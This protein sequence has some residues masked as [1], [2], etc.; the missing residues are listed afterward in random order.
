MHKYKK[1]GFLLL[2]FGVIFYGCDAGNTDVIQEGEYYLYYTNKEGTELT[3][4]T[5][6]PESQETLEVAKEML[7]R[8]SSNTSDITKVKTIPTGVAVEEINIADN[9]AS[10]T[11]S[12]EFLELD[13][14]DNIIS[15]SSVVLTLT[16][17]SDIQYVRMYAGGEELKDQS[18]NSIGAMQAGD[19]INATADIV[20]LYTKTDITLYFTNE[21][22]DMLKPYTYESVISNKMSV[23]KYIV[24]QL[25]NGPTEAG[26]GR[27]ISD[28]V[29]LIGV[30]TKDDICYVNLGTNFLEESM[31]IKSE[32][33]I[34]SIVN[35]LS[36]LSYINKVQIMVNGET[37][38]SY[39][40]SI[41]LSEAL[42]R[43]LD[44]IE[45]FSDETTISIIEE[46]IID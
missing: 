5:F 3:T 32:I 26:Y 44:Y 45:E 17:L 27:V 41:S 30:T 39:H 37:D 8:L 33:T 23:E 1:L 22:G 28:K 4:M 13:A 10:I 11:F 2:I 43:N 19:F 34:Y 9:I 25:I 18:G 46:M 14:I 6:T 16:Q 38:K 21:K 7:S 36:E 29:E 24:E 12:S 20:N 35:S 31:D 15:R 42:F 40:S